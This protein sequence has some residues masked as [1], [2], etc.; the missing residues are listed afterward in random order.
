MKTKTKPQDSSFTGPLLADI[1]A[2]DKANFEVNFPTPKAGST[3]LAQPALYQDQ[4][5]GYNL[6]F[7]FPQE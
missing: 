6:D 1:V 5:S 2:R 7:V 3:P 4:G